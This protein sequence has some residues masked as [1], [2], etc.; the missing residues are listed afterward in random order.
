MADKK[1]PAASASKDKPA[2]KKA[3]PAAKGKSGKK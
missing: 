1:K 3:P 2:D